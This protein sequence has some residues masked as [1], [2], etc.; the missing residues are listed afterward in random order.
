[1]GPGTK[2]P[3]VTYKTT[4]KVGS[5]VDVAW[6]VAANHGGG[7]LYRLC[8]RDAELTEECFMKTPLEF[9][10]NTQKL[11]WHNGDEVEID[12]TRVS[13]GVTPEGSTWTRNPLPPCEGVGAG[14]Q[15]V[16]DQGPAFPPPKGCNETCWGYQ[17]CF[18]GEFP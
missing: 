6:G 13:E 12:A 7:Y 9:H 11:V 8:P 5:V 15:G 16:C 3:P 17:P 1:M 10:G 2:L 4:W 18:L 14:F